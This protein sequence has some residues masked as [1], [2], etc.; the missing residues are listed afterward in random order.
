VRARDFCAGTVAAGAPVVPVSNVTGAGIDELKA[1]IYDAIVSLPSRR[2][3]AAAF[4]PVDRVFAL[5]GH[6]TIVTGTLMQGTIRMGDVLELQPAGRTVRVR[7][8]QIFGHKVDSAEAGSRVA[9]NI[10]AVDVASIRRG[11]VLTANHEFTPITE[12]MVEFTPLP[13][14]L[15]LVHRRTPV[16][17]A[18]GSAE[19][20]GRLVVKERPVDARAVPARLLL[21]RPTVSYRG[22]RLIVRRLSPKDLLGGAIFLERSTSMP[23][24]RDPEMRDDEACFEV[25]K[26]AGLAPMSARDVASGANVREEVAAAAVAWLVQVGRIVAIP[27]PLGYISR[28]ADDDA[29]ASARRLIL[30]RHERQPWRLGCSTA[31]IAASIGTSDALAVR[32]LAAWHEDGRIAHRAR[33]WHLPD[34]T[35]SLTK[36]QL[37]FFEGAL[38]AQTPPSLLPASYDAV[39]KAA[40][41]TRLPGGADALESLI[42]TG[43]LVRIGD[44]LYRRA[45]MTRAQALVTGVLQ[46]NVAG[47]TTSQLKEAF[48]TSRKY[49]LPLLEHLDSIGFTI[50]DGD[51]RRLRGAAGKSGAQVQN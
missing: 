47:A 26:S 18:I 41:S 42:A 43:T 29:F 10:P 1:A 13:D 31:E 46:N 50:R 2:V 9:V 8:L 25:I 15:P 22:S 14:A 40:D 33:N 37:A 23:T 48:G 28:P 20:E 44:D 19:I 27:K 11:D 34:F 49:A 6:G 51:L 35:P 3:D 39:A 21:S 38:I 45:Q 36:D 4:L 17:V 16:R 30:E 24:D 32:L 7:S 12:L 5:Q